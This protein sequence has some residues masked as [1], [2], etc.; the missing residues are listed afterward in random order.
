MPKARYHEI[1]ESLKEGITSGTY[2]YQTLLPSENELC[3][4]YDCSRSTIRRALSQL[5]T[6]G[7]TQPMQGKGVCVIW[8][9][10]SEGFEGYAMSGLE[11]FG[12]Q[13]RRVGFEPTTRVREFKRLVADEELAAR[14]G[15]FEGEELLFLNRVRMA[16]GT[17]VS[18]ERTYL[19]GS[20]FPEMTPEDA[21]GSIFAYYE[22][23]SGN[24]I[25]SSRRVIRMEAANEDDFEALGDIVPAAVGILDC[26]TFGSDGSLLESSHLRQ[27][28]S[29][30]SVLE[31][32]VRSAG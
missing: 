24:R 4:Q 23:T 18:L 5:A 8:R 20:A 22:A 17:P 11:S 13:S 9:P 28:P 25:A 21:E 32:S 27:S 15:F 1:Y 14:T 29:H 12:E 6:D 2:K 10:E 26:H 7:Y 19:R 3:S 30:F 31:V 16:N